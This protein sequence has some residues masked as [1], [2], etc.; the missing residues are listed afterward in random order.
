MSFSDIS[1]RSHSSARQRWSPYFER[2]IS[3]FWCVVSWIAASILF[4]L[5]VRSTGGVTTADANSSINSTW[6]VAH[7]SLACAYPPTNTLGGAPTTAPLYV[8]L[9]GGLAALFRVGNGAAFPTSAQMGAHCSNAVTL[10]ERWDLRSHALSSTVLIG[11]VGW[12]AILTGALMILRAAGRGRTLSEPLT[13]VLLVFVAPIYICLH[14]YF[15]PQ[16]L[17]AM[18]LGMVAIA[19]SLRDRWIL[20]GVFLALA[21]TSQQ[22]AVLIAVPIVIVAPTS[23]LWKCTVA[24]ATTLLVVDLPLVIITSGRSIDAIIYGTAATTRGGTWLDETH[25]TGPLLFRVARLLPLA[26]GFALA[27]YVRRRDGSRALS[28]AS[29]VALVAVCLIL[30]LVFEVNLWG[31]YFMASAVL[32]LILDLLRRRF[33]VSYVA[34]LLLVIYATIDGG[35]ATTHSLVTLPTW[36]WQIILVPTALALALGPLFKDT[37]RRSDTIGVAPNSRSNVVNGSEA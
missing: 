11:Y 24:F 35:L 12:L 7:G 18:G 32:L 16:D 5:L 13:A 1:R 8:L 23:R 33:R 36:L 6:A 2:P 14:Q 21:I 30:R 22:F 26:T 34:W 10:I 3:T 9:S 28:P 4:L 20:V 27:L 25:L 29:L 15:H 31:Y 17:I 37:E 19:T